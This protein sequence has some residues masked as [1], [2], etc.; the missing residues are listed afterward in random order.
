MSLYKPGN[1][2]WV[3]FTAPNGQQ[4]RWLTH[5]EA[6]RLLEELPDHLAEMVRFTLATGLREA[7][8][9]QLQWSQVD[10]NRSC[11]NLDW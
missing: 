7:N 9:T 6:D 8:V 1:T 2:W 10:M 5:E 4:V 3:R 11:S